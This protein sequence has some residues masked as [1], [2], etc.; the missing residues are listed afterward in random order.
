MASAFARVLKRLYAKGKV[1][2]EDVA[3]RV[4]SG[5]LTKEDYK[6]V[7]GEEYVAD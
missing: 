5:K 6:Y 1:T 3:A 4:V 7:T 2:K